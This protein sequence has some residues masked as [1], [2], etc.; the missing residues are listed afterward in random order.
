M[1]TARE[2]WGERGGGREGR[3]RCFLYVFLY[4]PLTF[5]FGEFGELGCGDDEAW[6]S[7]SHSGFERFGGAID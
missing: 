1:G 6:G 2:R 4:L 7:T 3:G 5:L